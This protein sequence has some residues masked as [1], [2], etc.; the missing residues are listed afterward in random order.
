MILIWWATTIVIACRIVKSTLC[1]KCGERFLWH[2]NN[3]NNSDCGD[4]NSN[5]RQPST[6]KSTINEMK[7]NEINW[8]WYHR[9]FAHCFLSIRFFSLSLSHPLCLSHCVSSRPSFPFYLFHQLDCDP[10]LPNW[11]MWISLYW[12]ISVKVEMRLS[13]TV[14]WIEM[15]HYAAISWVHL[16]GHLSWKLT[17]DFCIIYFPFL[18]SQTN[19]TSTFCQKSGET[20]PSKLMAID[21]VDFNWKKK[22]VRCIRMWVYIVSETIETVFYSRNILYELMNACDATTW[23]FIVYTFYMRIQYNA[24]MHAC[25]QYKWW[26]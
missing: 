7:L 25:V 19:T 23:W 2:S 1:T 10:A 14:C 16:Y 8:L 12:I 26:Q 15:T 18:W 9:I 20:D 24:C 22:K 3:N 11:I 21:L 5:S 4:N 13:H 17:I 6:T